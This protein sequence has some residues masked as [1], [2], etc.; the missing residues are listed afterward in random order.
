MSTP[1]LLLGFLNSHRRQSER[2]VKKK[3]KKKKKE[4]DEGEG[5]GGKKG[6]VLIKREEGGRR[7]G[8]RK[9]SGVFALPH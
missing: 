6:R 9:V 7:K 8:G 4:K 5:E 2:V 1:F 3:K